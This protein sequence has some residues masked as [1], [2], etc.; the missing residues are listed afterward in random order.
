[1][2]AGGISPGLWE[3]MPWVPRGQGGERDR[4]GQRGSDN[5]TTAPHQ[6]LTFLTGAQRPSP[7]CSSFP[8]LHDDSNPD[9]PPAGL[10]PNSTSPS[11]QD[12]LPLYLEVLRP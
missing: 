4:S 3:P 8:A 11:Q 1:M 12:R 9:H 7:S 6:G 5:P 10:P 2:G